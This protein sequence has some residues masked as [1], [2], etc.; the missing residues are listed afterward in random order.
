MT[1]YIKSIQL[2]FTSFGV[3]MILSVPM[4]MPNCSLTLEVSVPADGIP[5]ADQALEINS[6]V[7]D[8]WWAWF[9]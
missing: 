7:S 6:D 9:L 2:Q 1:D 4:M 8:F 5:L 3:G